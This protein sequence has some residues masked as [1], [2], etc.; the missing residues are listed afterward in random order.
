M[1]FGEYTYCHILTVF[2]EDGTLSVSR[3]NHFDT[4]KKEIPF[5]QELRNGCLKRLEK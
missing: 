3:A 2:Y 5:A 1:K 4:H